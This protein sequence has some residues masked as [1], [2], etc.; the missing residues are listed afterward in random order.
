MSNDQALPADGRP[1]DW[2]VWPELDEHSS[3]AM[4]RALLSGRLA[5]S[6]GKSLWPSQTV[7]AARTVARMSGRRHCVLTTSGSTSIVVALHA[8]GIGPGD[9][10]AMTAA[11]WV[12]CATSVL[13]VGA[14]PVFFDATPESPCGDPA[15]LAERPSAILGIHLFAQHFDVAAARARFPGV[16]IIEDA[17]HTQFG[18]TADGSRIGSLGDLSIMSLQ[19]SKIITSGEGGAIL[20][21]DEDVLHRLESLVMDSRRRAALNSPIAW[22]ELVPANLLHG[23]NQSPP[24]YTGALL[25]DQLGR[26]PAQ[27]ERRTAGARTLADALAGSGWEMVT[28]EAAVASG[29]FYGIIVRIPE[30]AGTPDEVMSAVERETGLVISTVYDPVAE[31]PLYLPETIKQ[32]AALRAPAVDLP[33]ARAWFANSVMISHMAFLAPAEDLRRLAAVLRSLEPG[34]KTTVPIHASP[35]P[36]T[37]V[38]VVVITK[39]ERDTLAGTLASALKQDAD[40]T[41]RLTVWVDGD[42][43]PDAIAEVPCEVIRIAADGLLPTEPFAR[44][45]ALRD[46]AA[47]RCTADYV[48]FLDD[49]NEW[50]TNHLSTLLELTTAGYPVA[51]SWRTLVSPDGLPTT[52]DRFPWRAPSTAAE[53]LL[54]QLAA[55]DVMD[56]DSPT[57]RD[58]A[59]IDGVPGLPGMVDM[60][61]WLFD[62]DA[63]RLLR[64]SRPRTPAEAEARLGEDDVLLEQIHRLEFPVGRTAQ[65]TL[66][67]RLGGMSTPEYGT[68]QAA[69]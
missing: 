22:N 19:A 51:H 16:P 35:S 56:N 37:T 8:L 2:P 20:T 54:T 24:E 52:V 59:T 21:D 45:A 63:L 48:A 5:V 50:D 62:R 43:V 30:G 11:T 42:R 55:A 40:A 34:A 44:I 28:D 18:L 61:E 46:L 68:G 65:P 1:I 67:Y 26:F 41:V 14:T 13:R 58:S 57:V 3:L 6:G 53:A 9:T 64:F 39:G 27:A 32:F 15:T 66:R 49:D 29:S 47:T 17:S 60:G 23:S 33:H 25:A 38:D 7:T 12:A 69:E 31:G 36:T 4:A 10:V